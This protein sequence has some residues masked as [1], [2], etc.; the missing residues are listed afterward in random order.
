MA[1]R[2]Q[3]IIISFKVLDLKWQNGEF[4]VTTMQ[5]QDIKAALTVYPL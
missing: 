5:S 3:L 4:D 1:V 2:S